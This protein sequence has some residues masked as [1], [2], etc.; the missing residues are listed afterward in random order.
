MLRWQIEMNV[1]TGYFFCHICRTREAVMFHPRS[2][3]PC[4]RLQLARSRLRRLNILLLAAPAKHP[5]WFH[6]QFTNQSFSMKSFNGL[7]W[8]EQTQPVVL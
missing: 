8:N 2:G 4:M 3:A 1:P 7:G 5:K 6:P